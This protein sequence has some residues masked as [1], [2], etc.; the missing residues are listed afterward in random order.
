MLG[1]ELGS[2]SSQQ[3]QQR[4]DGE[5]R[6]AADPYINGRT[7]AYHE[8]TGLTARGTSAHGTAS[9]TETP[10]KSSRPQ[11][12]RQP[13]S[14]F[15]SSTSVKSPSRS[16]NRIPSKE[17]L[18]TALNLAQQAV[19]RD[20]AN[21]IPGAISLYRDA[22]ERL[23]TVMGRVG[24]TLEPLSP[25]LGIP[26]PS[27]QEKADRE[28][29]AGRRKTSGAGQSAEEG[30]TLMGIV[31]SCEIRLFLLAKPH[32][33]KH[34]AYVARIRLLAQMNSDVPILPN[35][36]SAGILSVK[37]TETMSPYFSPAQSA[38][39]IAPSG[40]GND[41][42]HG[43]AGI[44]SASRSDHGTQ[45]DSKALPSGSE[46][47]RLGIILTDARPPITQRAASLSAYARQESAG[48][49][50]PSPTFGRADRSQADSTTSDSGIPGKSIANTSI[51][52][53]DH[54]LGSSSNMELTDSRS[55]NLHRPVPARPARN[56]LRSPSQPVLRGDEGAY[57]MPE[58]GID[59][60]SL[61]TPVEEKSPS[62]ER[63]DSDSSI[64]T[65]KVAPSMPASTSDNV[66]PFPP[67]QYPFHLL[68]QIRSSMISP[69][70]APV[71]QGLYIPRAAWSITGVK[72]PA[73]DTKIRVMVLLSQSLS[74][75]MDSG[76]P[77]LQ[78]SE[79][80]KAVS[81]DPTIL[82]QFAAA[83]DDLEAL[84]TE[85]QKLLAK[86]VGDSKAFAKPRKANTVRSGLP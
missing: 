75:V 79:S 35:S 44:V 74:T 84:A 71:S 86:K 38:S 34:D 73:L 59:T 49:L 29:A 11:S 9:P 15:D 48:V 39:Q 46:H 78:T 5:R 81:V 14:T 12:N 63:R 20:G 17:I 77:L 70:G 26:E 28:A 64:R 7:E 1:T 85:I 41:S 57:P 42:G 23:R 8:Q 50:S 61:E 40:T 21:D 18:Q 62:Q 31:S 22:V 67:A 53:A 56:P 3:A 13:S 66:A 37:S 25:D 10:T 47:G 6:D 27:Q 51:E 69:L 43:T 82:M 60:D 55:T 68:R 54:S 30:K 24:L 16:R 19:E 33:F 58:L 65:F 83:L 52:P 80:Q 32:D 76:R 2:G 72:L 36:P 45:Q 4:S